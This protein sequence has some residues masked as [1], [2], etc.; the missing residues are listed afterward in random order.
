QQ[1]E[2]PPGGALRLARCRVLSRWIEQGNWPADSASPERAGG[3]REPRAAI[4]VE[5]RRQRL[6][7]AGMIAVEPSGLLRREHLA[8]DHPPLDRREGEH[9]E[10]AE[11]LLGA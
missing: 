10:R 9:L 6:E 4:G 5:E 1:R 8:C 3:G 2:Q 7:D 11:R